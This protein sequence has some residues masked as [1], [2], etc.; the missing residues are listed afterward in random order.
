[1]MNDR[2]PPIRHHRKALCGA[3][4]L[5]LGGIGAHRL[6]LGARWWWIYPL[7]ALPAMGIALRSEPWY[8]HPA[9]FVATLVALAAMLEAIVFCLTPDEKWDARHNPGSPRRSTSGWPEALVAIVALVLGATLLMSV[10]AIALEGW[11]RAM[12]VR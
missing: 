9:F 11:V 10:M 2:S 5:F 3:L 6:Y 7:L 12:G 8:R 4:A 1:M